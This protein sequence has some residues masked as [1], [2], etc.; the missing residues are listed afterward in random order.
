MVS[1]KFNVFLP[2]YL[3]YELRPFDNLFLPD[4]VSDCCTV[5][6]SLASLRKYYEDHYTSFDFVD[7]AAHPCLFADRV[8]DFVPLIKGKISGITYGYIILSLT[9]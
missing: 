8:I 3:T 4:V 9:Y 7:G 6:G 1:K 5:F 2:C